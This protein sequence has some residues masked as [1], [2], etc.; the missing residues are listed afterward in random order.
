MWTKY[1]WKDS[2]KSF[3]LNFRNFSSLNV[4]NIPTNKIYSFQMSN[5]VCFT[6]A[7]IESH[8]YCS[9]YICSYYFS[10]KCSFVLCYINK[11]NVFVHDIVWAALKTEYDVILEVIR[12][13][14]MFDNNT[15]SINLRKQRKK[16]NM[17]SLKE[18]NRNWIWCHIGI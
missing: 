1:F 5:A 12:I 17:E 8:P 7:N 3:Y 13:F 14:L 18:L 11:F 2:G 4:Y 9:W 15:R 16:V 10:K 6:T